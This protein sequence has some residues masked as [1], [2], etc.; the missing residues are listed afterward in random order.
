MTIR[1]VLSTTSDVPGISAGLVDRNATEKDLLILRGVEAGPGIQIDVVDFDLGIYT[2]PQKKIVIQARG[3]GGGAIGEINRASNL[4]SGVGLWADKDGDAL[5]F[6]SLVAPSGSGI[7]LTSSGQE[8]AIESTAITGAANLGSGY[9]VLGPTSGSTLQFRTLVAGPNIELAQTA[10]T[11]QIATT[12]QNNEGS[13]LGGVGSAAL[14]VGMDQSRLTF[15]SLRAGNNVTLAESTNEI[16]INAIDTG[17]ITTASNLVPVDDLETKAIFAQKIASDLQFKSLRAGTNVTL[18]ATGSTVTIDAAGDLTNGVNRGG[19]G[20]GR[21]EVLSGKAGTTL[22]FRRLVAGSNVTLSQTDDLITITAT[23]T[24]EVNTGNS[25]GTGLSGEEVYAGKTDLALNFRR[26]KAG[27]N[28]QIS[29]DANSIIISTT[30]TKG[31]A[32]IVEDASPQLGGDLDVQNHAIISTANRDI[33]ISANGTGQVVLD[34]LRWPNGDGE[35]GQVLSTDGAG[36]LSWTTASDGSGGEATTASNVGSAGVGVLEGQTDADLTFK[37]LNGSSVLS[38]TDN[39]A[40]HRIDLGI[41]IDSLEASLTLGDIG[42]ILP[43]GKGGTGGETAAQARSNLELGTLATQNTGSVAITGGTINGTAIGGTL[44]AAGTF[45]NL[46]ASGTITLNGSQWP[47]N[48]GTNGQVLTTDGSGGMIWSTVAGGGSETGEAN[49]GS[50]VGTTGTGLYKTKVGTILQFHKLNAGSNKVTVGLDSASD[51]VRIDVAEGSLN[52]GNMTGSPTVARGGTGRS[53]FTTNA[54]L[55]GSPTGIAETSVPTTSGTVLTWTNGGFTWASGTGEMNDGRSVGVGGVAVYKGTSG[56]KLEF[57]TINVASNRLSV[58][59]DTVNSEVDLDV[60]EA[61]LSLNDIGG[62]RLSVARG[63]TGSTTGTFTANGLLIG[64][65]T[66]A[67]TSTPAPSAANTLLRWNG[68]SYEW[69]TVTSAGEANTASNLGSG[70]QVFSAKSGVDLQFRTL[71]AGSTKITVTQSGNLINFDIAESLLNVGNMTGTLAVNHGGTGL[72]SYTAGDILYAT[73]STTLATKAKG[74]NSTVLKVGPTGTLDY[75][76]LDLTADVTGV[77]KVENGGTGAATLAAKGVLVGNGTAAITTITAPT[78]ADQV[79]KYDGTNIVWGT[80]AGTGGGTG[81]PEDAQYLVL[82]GHAGLT[83]E[84]VLTLGTGLSGSNAGTDGGAYTLSV[85]DNTTTQKIQVAYNGTTV[86]NARKKINFIA[87]TGIGITTADNTGTPGDERIDVTITNTA[88]QGAGGGGAFT[89]PYEVLFA[90]SGIGQVASVT[91]VPSGWTVTGTGTTLTV[92]SHNVA[93]EP[94]H[95]VWR[96][97]QA[98]GFRVTPMANAA[99]YIS[100]T[101]GTETSAFTVSGV[102]ATNCGGVNSG[103]VRAFIYF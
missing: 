7:R 6:K 92:S 34:G 37:R 10:N 52:I 27:E 43:L 73:G 53:A 49:D 82:S 59:D 78:A 28:V 20:F 22:E 65:G 51:E 93:L 95:I 23:D 62:D 17:E 13:N 69:G 2:T 68:T 19:S 81:A 90:L 56:G 36:S 85:A 3:A 72:T 44:P 5:R 96:A 11:L 31:L 35:A 8:I 4:G 70:A 86:A 98:G 91:S 38:V 100:L 103:T 54:V 83:N 41:N 21:V 75:A 39:T 77:L 60:V 87:G 101:T 16:T 66:S 45:T 94:R 102:N 97:S 80:V 50:N 48:Q 47:T 88:G 84:R 9:E 76:K 99:Q 63:G 64:N 25:L 15:R 79:L 58:N 71:A 18:S 46:T 14:Y 89:G 12:A 67:F 57:K 33:L 29:S 40:E 30:D 61:N 55:I 26:I 42:G 74:G 1:S 24:G 32:D